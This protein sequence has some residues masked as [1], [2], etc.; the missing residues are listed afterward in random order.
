MATMVVTQ[1]VG[2]TRTSGG[3]AWFG[4]PKSRW[5]TVTWVVFTLV[6]CLYFA[7]SYN[8]QTNFLDLG[9]YTQGLEKTPYQYR[10]LMMYVF[11]FLIKLPVTMAL[12]RHAE[13]MH[14]PDQ[15]K[16][17]EQL[18]QILTV[19]VSLF[20]AVLATAGTLKKLT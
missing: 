11:H 14:V 13:H 3:G 9:A 7:L 10:A 15:F 5:K 18:A 19:M 12:A 6:V 8:V 1:G 20:A 4:E 17:P 16:R 2:E